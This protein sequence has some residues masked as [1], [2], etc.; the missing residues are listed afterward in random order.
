MTAI[1]WVLL[2]CLTLMGNGQIQY[3][4]MISIVVKIDFYITL[5]FKNHTDI[6]KFML[7]RSDE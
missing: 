7:L 2:D 6:F 1:N 5:K 3:M 4:L